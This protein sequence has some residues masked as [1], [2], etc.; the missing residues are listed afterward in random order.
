MW[1]YQ[2]LP[3]T[4]STHFTIMTQSWTIGFININNIILSEKY[5]YFS[6]PL[7]KN[8]VYKLITIMFIKNSRFV[9]IFN[10]IYSAL[11]SNI[12]VYRWYYIL[13]CKRNGSLSLARKQ[14]LYSKT[15]TYCGP[16]PP[17]AMM[18]RTY[19][20]PPSPANLVTGYFPRHDDVARISLVAVA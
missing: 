1:T 16:K 15:V 7:S 8:I 17:T 2:A 3:P 6:V 5:F 18:R 19:C 11:F 14:L 10:K 4:P 9:A 12:L 13:K 20:L